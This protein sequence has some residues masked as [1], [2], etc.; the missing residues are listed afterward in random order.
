IKGS[1]QRTE[2]NREAKYYAITK[3]GLR[4]LEQE[5]TRWRRLAALVD[6][7]LLNEG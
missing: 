5:T 7:L 4:G 2:H 3:S 6:K 1:W